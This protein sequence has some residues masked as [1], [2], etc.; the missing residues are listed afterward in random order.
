MLY[1]ALLATHSWLRWAVLLLGLLAIARALAG[2]LGG[3]SWGRSDDRT[4]MFF[5]TGLDVQMLLGV[6]LYF[7]LSPVTGE[8][9]RD[10]GAAMGNAAMRFWTVE[11][12]FGMLLGLALAHVGRA[13]IRKTADAVRRHRVAL[14]FF[15]LSMLVILATIPWPFRAY[16][17]P[18]FRALTFS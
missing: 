14:I 4:A 15:T 1:S 5:T 13:R 6:I 9:M 18:L 3:R 12:P 17:R 7:A 10:F 2:H 8:G 16:G 11:H